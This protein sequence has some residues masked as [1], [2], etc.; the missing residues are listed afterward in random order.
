MSMHD[1]L[2]KNGA[3]HEKRPLPWRLTIAKAAYWLMRR[4]LGVALLVLAIYSLL[5]FAAPVAMRLGWTTVGSA[6]YDVYS[7][8]CHQMAQRSLFLFGPQAM[9]NL[10]ELP[11][12]YS[13]SPRDLLLLRAFRGS[14]AIGWKVAWSDRMVYMYGGLLVVGVVYRVR[15]GKRPPDP[16]RLRWVF[17]LMLPLALDGITHFVSDQSGLASGFR[18]D[19]GWLAQAT[20]FMLPDE[21]Y[22]GDA[23]G[24]FNSLVRMIS[25]FWFA[26]GLGGLILP[27]ID[28][29]MRRSAYSLGIKLGKVTHLPMWRDALQADAASQG[30]QVEAH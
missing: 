28:H 6:I 12:A 14:E 19:N 24:S 21:F 16:M 2:D 11:L 17:L 5:P 18:Y 20:G 13:G 23:I 22:R 25:G 3:S 26:V 7:T 10:D 27:L 30:Q 8:Q 9:Y 1:A 4:W 15:F 29:N